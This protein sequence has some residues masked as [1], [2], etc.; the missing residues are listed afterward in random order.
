LLLAM[1]LSQPAA[2]VVGSGPVNPKG[3]NI[4]L[5]PQ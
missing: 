5:P 4:N 2:A 1:A 3:E